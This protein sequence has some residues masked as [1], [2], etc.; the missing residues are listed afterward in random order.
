MDRL[1]QGLNSEVGFQRVQA[2]PG[3][4][5]PGMPVHNGDQIQKA[6]TS[7]QVGDHGASDLVGP[8]NEQP[9][10]QIG[11]GLVRL[12]T[13]ARIGLLVDQHQAH[14][15]QTDLARRARCATLIQ[16]VYE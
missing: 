8:L 2:A 1:V 6:P 10:Q 7:G 16:R 12:R 14:E 9:A 4:N 15:A 3:Q 11:E 5:L 13:S